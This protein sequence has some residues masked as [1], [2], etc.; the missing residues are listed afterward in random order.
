VN[1]TPYDIGIHAVITGDNDPEHTMTTALTERD[2]AVITFGSVLLNR[3]FP[4]CGGA[5]NAL[6]QKLMQVSAGQGFLPWDD[7]KMRDLLGEA[8]DG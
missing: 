7:D 5:A 3:L 6:N 8:T 2:L 1:G 4:E